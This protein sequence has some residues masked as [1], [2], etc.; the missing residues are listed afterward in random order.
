[1]A[2]DQRHGPEGRLT[3]YP[4][5]ATIWRNESDRGTYFNV[6]ISKTFKDENG[7]YRDTNS[8]SSDD[9]LR[10]SE[11]ARSAHHRV[12]ELKRELPRE[13][14]RKENRDEQNQRGDLGHQAPD[15]RRDNARK[16]GR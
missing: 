1:M 13:I 2:E 16:R 12:N 8:I 6:T 14:G 4:Y 3:D 11:L 15:R 5:K 10:V 9:L 7:D